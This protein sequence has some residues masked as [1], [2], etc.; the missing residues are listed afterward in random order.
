MKLIYP[1]ARKDE[2]VVDIMHSVEINVRCG[3]FFSHLRSLRCLC[4]RSLKKVTTTDL[5]NPFVA[6]GPLSVR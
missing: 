4:A 1:K 2:E 5:E 3:L 6:V